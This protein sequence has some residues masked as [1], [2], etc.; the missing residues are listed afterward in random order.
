MTS[1][2]KGKKS[3][4]DAGTVVL[5][6]F[7]MLSL[8][9]GILIGRVLLSPSSPPAAKEYV[10]ESKA[11]GDVCARTCGIHPN[12]AV[13]CTPIFA[14]DENGALRQVAC[15]PSDAKSECWY[16]CVAGWNA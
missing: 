9:F 8:F 15:E 3:S 12:A 2:T 14:P 16:H 6:V 13:T 7:M 5:I 10:T 4:N 1:T 11:A